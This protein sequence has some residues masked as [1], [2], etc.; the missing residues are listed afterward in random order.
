M[1]ITIPFLR[2]TLHVATSKRA[3]PAGQAL[4]QPGSLASIGG[5]SDWSPRTYGEYYPKSVPVYSAIKLRADSVARAP[6]RV[7]Q[8]GMKDGKA[9]KALVGDDHPVQSLMDRV[10]P[11][12]TAGDLW[13]ATETYMCLWGKA[14][15]LLEN[16]PRGPQEIWP[17]RPDKMR[18]I[19]DRDNYVKG[20]VYTE[21]GKEMRAFLP[22]EVVWFR[23]FNP[24][25]EWAGMSPIAPLRLSVDMGFDTLQ[26]NR[27]ASTNDVTPGFVIETTDT[28]SQ[29][30]VE[31]FWDRWEKKHQ[32]PTRVKRPA[33]LM[34]GMKA[35]N[36]GFSPR[37]MEY[38]QSLIWTLGDTA[39]AFGVPLPML[40]ELSRA[41][42]S[43]FITARRIFWE[44]TIVPRNRWYA[45]RLQEFLLPLF[46]GYKGLKA[47]F[48]TG[49]IEALQEDEVK[50][51]Q[52]RHI[53]VAD[54]VMTPNEIRAEMGLEPSDQPEADELQVGA[55][56]AAA[57]FGGERIIT[58]GHRTA[59]RRSFSRDRDGIFIRKVE[60]DFKALL[61]PQETSFLRMQARLFNEQMDGVIEKLNTYRSAHLMRSDNLV[62]GELNA[63]HTTTAV[64]QRIEPPTGSALFDPEEWMDIFIVRGGPLIE[65]GL[66]QSA[67]NAI[68][69]FKLGIAF[70]V[71][72]PITQRWITDRTAFW[73]GRVNQ[74][75]GKLV[76]DA[77]RRANEIGES[78]PQLAARLEKVR[79]YNRAARA[80][81]I[82]RTE[83]VSAQNEGHLASFEQAE[84][85]TKEWLTAHDERVRPDHADADGQV[86]KLR[87]DFDVGGEKLAAPGQGGSAGNVINCRCVVLPYGGD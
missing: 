87:E 55:G 63:A 26:A 20:F 36:M 33:V 35:T 15:W 54:G 77:V 7:Y 56:A 45:E 41:T 14:F 86:R 58:N 60:E 52:R 9:T 73:A 10:N 82:A 74:T 64:A 71:S 84:I 19:P 43:N 11:F 13:R 65:R 70:D 51:A 62:I 72:R 16:G 2:K 81:T 18:V 1:E 29:A 4:V 50:K 53:Y 37:D 83:M 69:Q 12:W 25:D 68:A 24:L 40:H 44:D 47:E 28:P 31:D 59:R 21:A 32:G 17:V 67:Q 79:T 30:E 34:G 78:I 76:T 75:T 46:R 22:E 49:D 48:D 27:Y 42:Y 85:E 39:R 8:K 80:V 23:E 38:I 5:A 66:R 6:I 3:H 61:E 57:P